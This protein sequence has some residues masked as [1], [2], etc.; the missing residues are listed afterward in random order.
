MNESYHVWMS[1]VTY[2]WA[3]SHKNESCPT[4]MAY[5]WV[6]SRMGESCHVL[7]H[8]LLSWLVHTC[9]D[10]FHTW[11]DWS[12]RDMTHPYV[13]RLIHTW[14]E[15]FILDLTHLYVTWLIHLSHDS[16]I[17]VIWLIHTWHDSSICDMTHAYVIRLI[18]TWHDSI[19]CRM[20]HSYVWCDVLTRVT[21]LI[22]TS[23]KTH[24]YLCLDSLIPV[25]SPWY[26]S[27]DL[28]TCDM[29]RSS[30]SLSLHVP[31]LIDTYH[32]TRIND[33]YHLTH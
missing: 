15:S 27:H 30:L 25:T 14:H 18:H 5:R 11:H 6:M 10:S 7:V 20:T 17:H 28:D 3:M 31:W 22:H 1:H 12:I 24:W 16:L 9:H 2:E 32:L 26:V 19:T 8:C 21:W 33:T 4:W 29:T 13:T 23:D